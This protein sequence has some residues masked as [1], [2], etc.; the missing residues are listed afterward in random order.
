MDLGLSRKYATIIADPPWEYDAPGQFGCTLD[1]RPNRD[2]TLNRLGAGSAS[3]Y[4]ALSLDALMAMNVIAV[5]EDNAHLY[6]WT[7]N[8]FLEQAY[9]LARAWGFEP[10]TIITWTKVQP[11]GKPSMKM[12]YY[13]RGATEHCLFCVRGRL[14]LKGPAHP[15]AILEPRT[16]HS[17]KPAYFFRMVEEQSPGPYL[18]LFARDVRLGWDKWG[19]QIPNALPFFEGGAA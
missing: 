16:P 17:V 6:L 8:A 4:G 14:R 19:N 5:A 1:H 9:P 2:R 12:G 13:Y 15:T 11:D 7:T 18:E 10:K 3:R